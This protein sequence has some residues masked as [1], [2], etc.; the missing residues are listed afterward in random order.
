[1]TPSVEQIV[2]VGAVT[3]AGAMA[4]IALW[5]REALFDGRSDLTSRGVWIFG[6]GICAVLVALGIAGFFV[7]ALG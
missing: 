5:R 7:L 6:L 2:E 1:M 4:G 3:V